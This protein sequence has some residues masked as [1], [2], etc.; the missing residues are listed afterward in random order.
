MEDWRYASMVLDRLQVNINSISEAKL[1][2][3]QNQPHVFSALHFLRGD[4]PRVVWYREGGTAHILKHN[5]TLPGR[6]EVLN[7]FTPECGGKNPRGAA[8]R[9]FPN[10][11]GGKTFATEQEGGVMSLP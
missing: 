2:S 8:P 6:R 5:G 3:I 7:Y 9:G 1:L 4:G 10:T 11:R